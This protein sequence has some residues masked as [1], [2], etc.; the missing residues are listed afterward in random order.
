MARGACGCLDCR[1]CS[2]GPEEPA[3]LLSSMGTR[4]GLRSGC[5]C[6]DGTTDGWAV[7]AAVRAVGRG[8]TGGRAE[9]W[10]REGASFMCTV[11]GLAEHLA[12]CM[13]AQICWEIGLMA[14]RRALH[15]STRWKAEGAV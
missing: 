8:C 7:G 10:A 12:L 4:L 13:L 6:A 15:S 11:R 2:V 9:A 5:V 3:K 14:S 1:D